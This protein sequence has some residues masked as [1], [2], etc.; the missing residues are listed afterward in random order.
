M[1]TFSLSGRRT[2]HYHLNPTILHELRTGRFDVVV[3]PGYA[4]SASQLGAT[5]CRLTGIPYVMFSET[6]LLDRR[7]APLRL[8]L[9]QRP[10]IVITAHVNMSGVGRLAAML[11][12]I[13][14][15]RLRPR[16]LL[17]S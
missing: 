1:R 4:M 17:P 6:T 14:P 12:G 8:A 15:T 16:D 7:A 10:D 2:F 3:L 5:F 9:R 11:T 13:H